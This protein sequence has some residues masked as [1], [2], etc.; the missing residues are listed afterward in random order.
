MLLHGVFQK[1]PDLQE[2]VVVYIKNNIS[3]QAGQKYAEQLDTISFHLFLLD[4]FDNTDLTRETIQRIYISDDRD[5]DKGTII[6]KL[7]SSYVTKLTKDLGILE[8]K[9]TLALFHQLCD[10]VD[11]LIRIRSLKDMS[12]NYGIISDKF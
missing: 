7:L 3:L 5:M 11:Q 12:Y 8:T 1:N 10:A 9:T 2:H 4:I 6:T